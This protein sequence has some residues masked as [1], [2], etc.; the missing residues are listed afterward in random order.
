L[1]SQL[2][3]IGSIKQPIDFEKMVDR[4]VRAKAMEVAGKDKGGCY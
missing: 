3:K 1:T 2:V 4:D